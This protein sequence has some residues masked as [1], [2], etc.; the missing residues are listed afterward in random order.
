MGAAFDDP[1]FIEHQDQV[2]GTHRR[3]AMS[4]HDRRATLPCDVEGLLDE[5]LGCG[6]EVRGGLVEDDHGRRLQ[7]QPGDRQPLPFPA[8]EPVAPLPHHR[9]ETLG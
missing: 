9:V 5:M 3:E 6:V 1:A 7:Q 8:A 2:R 4:H